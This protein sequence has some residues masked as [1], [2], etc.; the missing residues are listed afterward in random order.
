M[1][2]TG[3]VYVCEDCLERHRR[4]WMKAEAVRSGP[5]PGC[6]DHV[7][8]R[9]TFRSVTAVADAEAW[10]AERPWCRTCIRESARKAAGL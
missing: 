7:V 4:A 3:R 1:T 8:E 6:G 9:C 2:T 10:R 5:C